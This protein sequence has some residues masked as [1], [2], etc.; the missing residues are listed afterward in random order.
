VVPSDDH[1]E[2]EPL[3]PYDCEAEEK[4]VVPSNNHTKEERMVSS[5]NNTKEE[6]EAVPAPEPL[7]E[8][9]EQ[10][11]LRVL[12]RSVRMAKLEDLHR[13]HVRAHTENMPAAIYQNEHKNA[14]WFPPTSQIKQLF[15]SSQP[16]KSIG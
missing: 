9:E 13:R 3:V 1:N 5:N 15:N 7:S 4:L 16:H 10:A 2:E 14:S 8:P 6:E 11:L 12:V